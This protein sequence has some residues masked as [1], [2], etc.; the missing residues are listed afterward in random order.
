MVA[1]LVGLAVLFLASVPLT[2]WHLAIAVQAQ[3]NRVFWLLDFTAAFFIAWWISAAIGSS[4]RR[5]SIVAIAVLGLVSAVR[6]F[7]VTRIEADRALVSVGLPRNDWTDAMSW[8]QRQPSSWLVLANPNHAFLYGPGVRVAA[9]RDT[10]LEASKDGA[11][12]MYDRASALRV[13]AR[14]RA[15]ASF[16]SMTT[17][18]IRALDATYGI[19]V[20]VERADRPFDFPVLYRNDQFVV[21]GVR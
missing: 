21:Y 11:I 3:V 13:D 17:A 8:I 7:Y 1:G 18:D 6:G 15:L 20:L 14:I 9:L 10:V 19:D 4:G 12:A 5:V 2:A 16:D